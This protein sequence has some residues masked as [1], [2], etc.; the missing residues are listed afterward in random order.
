MANVAL[1]PLGHVHVE[2]MFRWTS[3]PEVRDNL[4]LRTVASREGTEAWVARAL[5]DESVRAF[6]IEL[7]GNHVGNVVLD[8]IDRHLGTARLHIYVG[9]AAAR[10]HGVGARATGLA[11]DFAFDELG[12]HKVWL[13][14]H[15]RNARAIAAYTKVGFRVEGTLRDEFLLNGGRVAAIYMGLLRNERVA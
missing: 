4:G 6:A 9:E 1:T 7:D 13:T 15:E 8:R 3:D 2:A 10:G 12:L 5:A 14:V 11:A